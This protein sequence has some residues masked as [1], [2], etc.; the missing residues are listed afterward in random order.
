MK[1]LKWVSTIALIA[2]VGLAV[3]G[4]IGC[5]DSDHNSPPA[6]TTNQPAQNSQP[7]V[8]YTCPMH[9]DVVQDKPGNCPKCGMRLVEKR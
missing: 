6:Q 5:T 4:V 8:K 2:V 7:A 9:P 3:I 1:R